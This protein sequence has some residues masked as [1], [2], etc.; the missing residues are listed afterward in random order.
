MKPGERVHF[1]YR[2]LRSDKTRIDGHFQGALLVALLG[3]FPIALYWIGFKAFGASQLPWKIASAV[4]ASGVL[5]SCVSYL[6]NRRPRRLFW[7]GLA[8]SV[9][10][11][12]FWLMLGSCWV[13]YFG[14]APMPF[15]I[16]IIALLFFVALTGFWIRR[17]WGNYQRATADQDLISKLYIKGPDRIVYPGAESDATVACIPSPWKGL[18]IPYWA[19][20][21]LAPLVIA[22]A[23]VSQRIFEKSG[24]PHGVFIILSVLSLP[25]S[26]GILDQFLMRTVF[27]HVYL[28]LKLERKTG[29]KVILGP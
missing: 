22:Y 19:V 9:V 27:F 5:T 8:A 3:C 17:S 16:R 4:V 12:T 21:I 2:D 14:F 7:E 18:P 23:F 11:L 6:L 24:G 15:W 26:N 29:K 20:A 25:M 13:F 1:E 10:S 28:A